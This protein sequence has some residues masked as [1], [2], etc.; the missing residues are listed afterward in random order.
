LSVRDVEARA[1]ERRH[2]AAPLVVCGSDPVD[3]LLVVKKGVQVREVR[4]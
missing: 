1:I 2:G 4:R 3:E